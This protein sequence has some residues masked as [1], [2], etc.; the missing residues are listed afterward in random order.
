M[1]AFPASALASRT[2]ATLC[3]PMWMQMQAVIG[4][5]LTYTCNKMLLWVVEIWMKSRLVC[6]NNRDVVNLQHLNLFPR[7]DK[8]R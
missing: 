6:D 3:F 4:L 1:G 5:A 2:E 7:N 8:Q